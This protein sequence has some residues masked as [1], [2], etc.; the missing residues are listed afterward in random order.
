MLAWQKCVYLGK[1]ILF[2]EG[3]LLQ[4]EVMAWLQFLL[5]VAVILLILKHDN[6]LLCKA[7]RAYPNN[8]FLRLNTEA[9]DLQ[10]LDS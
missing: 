1:I 3:T 2:V 9:Y 10:N 4:N 7:K 5:K 6:L 8:D